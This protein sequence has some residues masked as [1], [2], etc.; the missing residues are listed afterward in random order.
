MISAA[1]VTGE[2]TVLEIGPG[3]GRLTR[4][5]AESAGRVIAVEIDRDLYGKLKTELSGYQ[6]LELVLGDILRYPLETI[7]GPFKVV[8]NI[9]YH[10]S[11][12]IIFRLLEHRE[13]LVS[14]TLTLQKEVA[15][16][17]AAWPGGGD[18]GVLSIM[19]QYRGRASI[20]FPIPRGAF[21][22]VPRVDSA[23]LHV[24]ILPEPAVGVRDQKLFFSVVRTAF[25]MRRKTVL[26]T[27]KR[28]FPSAEDALHAAGVD[29]SRRP[30]TLHMEEFGRIADCLA[31]H[32][33]E[34]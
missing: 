6:N 26:N 11:T 12:P 32:T 33:G 3:P 31:V 10:I 9:P 22:P 29:P 20:K 2:D 15:E 7:G 8:A 17:I 21:R 28:A 30:E 24:D 25:S 18:Y 1:S 34:T 14:M 23:C 27:L 16:R 5:L 19:V 4:L 13:K